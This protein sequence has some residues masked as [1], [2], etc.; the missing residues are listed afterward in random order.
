MSV[1]EM[2]YSFTPATLIFDYSSSFSQGQV[3][4]RTVSLEAIQPLDSWSSSGSMSN[5]N[6]RYEAFRQSKTSRA[7]YVSMYTLCFKKD[8]ELFSSELCNRCHAIVPKTEKSH[9][10]T[11]HLHTSV[12]SAVK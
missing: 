4:S 6:C 7:G 2:S 3:R 1:S 8:H 12:T 9:L 10:F 5:Y 11:E